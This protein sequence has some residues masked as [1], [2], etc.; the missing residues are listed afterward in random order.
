LTLL[1]TPAAVQALIPFVFLFGSTWA[2][3]QLN[4]RSELAVMRSAG[5]SVWRLIGPA[6]LF[7]T[8]TGI[9][10]ITIY[11]PGASRMLSYANAV[12]MDKQ[13]KRANLVRV[14][15]DGIWLRQR[16][17]F[18]QIIVNARSHDS[19]AG[20]LQGV[21]V[22]RFDENSTFL[23][24]IDA[25]EAVLSGTTMELREARLRAPA[26]DAPRT[27]PTYA[28]ETALTAADL[29]ERVTAPETLSLW[30]LPRFIALA[31]TAGL[32]TIKYQ[33]RFHDLCSMPLKLL[34]MVLIA[35]AFS[36]RPVRLGGQLWLVLASIAA[37]FALYLTS[38][39]A[40]AL[41]ESELAPVALA[42]WSPAVIA[43]LIAISILLQLEEG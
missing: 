33:I 38:E 14:L 27:A 18:S 17:D 15:E 10:V 5:L 36:L 6:A 11:D 35:A 39:I 37:G 29:N 20:S 22:W 34:A 1:R 19:E 3:Y 43:A 9:F 4:K 31:E 12:K 24:R 41:G 7:A 13:S 8:L 23:E 16:D 26:D 42:A 40:T 28:I 25:G 2:F 32:P 21:T 30:R